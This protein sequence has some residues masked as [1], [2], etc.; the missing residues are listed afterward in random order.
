MLEC[1]GT[2]VDPVR[3]AESDGLSAWNRWLQTFGTPA[4]N[5][6]VKC[7]PMKLA[8]RTLLA[9]DY[10]KSFDSEILVNNKLD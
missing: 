10:Q 9:A 6:D 5:V 3:S 1:H 4:M 2:S 8:N 7:V